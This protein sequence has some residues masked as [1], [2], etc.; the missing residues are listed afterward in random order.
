MPIVAPGICAALLIGFFSIGSCAIAGAREDLTSFVMEASAFVAEATGEVVPPVSV[1]RGHRLELQV[2]IF[3]HM[4]PHRTNGADIAA[5]FNP[6]GGEVIIADDLD[7][8]APLG[9]SFLVHELVHSQQFVAGRHRQVKCV[10]ILEM[11]AYSVQ[12]RFLRARGHPREALLFEVLGFMQ[13]T[14]SQRY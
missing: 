6:I 3:G 7:L 8:S 10:G 12:A 13:A 4:P 14:C 9:L 1:R 11:E 2:S 5:T